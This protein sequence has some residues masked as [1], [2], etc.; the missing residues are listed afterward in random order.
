MLS[1]RAARSIH[2]TSS[3]SRRPQRRADWRGAGTAG[4][5][6]RRRADRQRACRLRCLL[7]RGSRA[8]RGPRWP[9]AAALLRQVRDSPALLGPPATKLLTRARGP[10]ASHNSLAYTPPSVRSGCVAVSCTS[11]LYYCKLEEELRCS[12]DELLESGGTPAKDV[13]L[14]VGELHI[15]GGLQLLSNCRD[16]CATTCPATTCPAPRAAPPA[17]R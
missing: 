2:R 10:G 5:G 8:G 16:G 6:S 12:Q 7:W 4:W 9:G 1:W 15:T 17:V 3:Y 11:T 13:Q 14:G